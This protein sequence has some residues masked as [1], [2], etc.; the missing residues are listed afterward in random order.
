MKVLDYATNIAGS[1]KVSDSQR[2]FRSYGRSVINST[3]IDYMDMSGGSTILIQLVD[4]HVKI[5]EV[6]INVRYD[7]EN[8]SSENPLFNGCGVLASLIGIILFRRPV[9]S[10]GLP[11]GVVA[12]AGLLLVSKSFTDVSSNIFFRYYPSFTGVLLVIFGILL[13]ISLILDQT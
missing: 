5:E 13:I 1:F 11:G 2:G 12:S 9:I 7:L 4:Q 10:I 8:T 3:K 6:T